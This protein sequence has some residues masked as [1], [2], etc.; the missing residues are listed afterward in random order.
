MYW[1][2]NIQMIFDFKWAKFAW[3]H[4]DG[5]LSTSDPTPAIHPGQGHIV[6]AGEDLRPV[7]GK[8]LRHW[9]TAGEAVSEQQDEQDQ[10][11][12]WQ[13]FCL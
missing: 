8:F 5:L 12:W 4:R 3:I 13:V 1:L 2:H 10:L 7:E 6:W 11:V 9:L